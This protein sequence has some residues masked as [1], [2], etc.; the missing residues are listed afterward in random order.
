MCTDYYKPVKFK[1]E[2]CKHLNRH[3]LVY[4]SLGLVDI[5]SATKHMKYKRFNFLLC[6]FT[7]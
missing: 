3:V 4:S 5:S 6:P 7:R 1:V 2:R